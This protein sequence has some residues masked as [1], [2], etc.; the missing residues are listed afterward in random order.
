M[1]A[2]G[3]LILVLAL[4]GC[5]AVVSGPRDVADGTYL[6]SVVHSRLSPS[7]IDGVDEAL[8]EARFKCASIRRQLSVLSAQVGRQGPLGGDRKAE[9]RFACIPDQSARSPIDDA[10]PDEGRPR[11]A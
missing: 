10:H 4:S 11:T 3:G 6:V 8:A 9:V 7:L 1:H 2:I 5:A